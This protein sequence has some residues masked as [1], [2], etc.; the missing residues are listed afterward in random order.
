MKEIQSLLDLARRPNEVQAFFFPTTKVKR[1][2]AAR[3]PAVHSSEIDIKGIISNNNSI[4]CDI[5]DRYEI[6]AETVMIILIL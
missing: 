1:G 3:L 4:E 2:R 6:M 5:S